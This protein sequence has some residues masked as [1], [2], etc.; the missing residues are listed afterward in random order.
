M[1]KL[2][3]SIALFLLVALVA[4]AVCAGCCSEGSREYIPGSGWKQ[5]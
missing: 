5:T 4:S 1:R 3:R 2:F